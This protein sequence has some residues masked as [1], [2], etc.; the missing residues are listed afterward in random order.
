MRWATP[1]QWYR[2]SMSYVGCITGVTK[3]GAMLVVVLKGLTEMLQVAAWL[4]L[5]LCFAF[6]CKMGWL[7]VGLAVLEGRFG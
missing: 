7:M 5:R 3:G 2:S 6:N 4:L 1:A